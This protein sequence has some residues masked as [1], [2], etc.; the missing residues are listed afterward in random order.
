MSSNALRDLD[1]WTPAE[2]PFMPYFSTPPR[3]ALRLFKAGHKN[4]EITDA[5]EKVA[6]AFNC[7]P[8]EGVLSH[9]MRR[10]LIDGPRVVIG[11]SDFEN[12]VD[13][14]VFEEGD[15]LAMDVAMST[16][17]GKTREGTERTTVFKRNVDATYNL[18]MKGAP[19][20]TIDH[21][22]SLGAGH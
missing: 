17:E 6:A 16:G 7:K 21:G 11:R 19:S 14:V 2:T 12:N 1:R 5:L 10:Y 20:R 18:K 8:V 15:V 9:N 22:C 3:P 13:E 4:H